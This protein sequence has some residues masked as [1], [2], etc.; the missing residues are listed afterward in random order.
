MA[1]NGSR[2]RD[3][4][5]NARHGNPIQLTLSNGSR[6][7]LPH[8]LLA[9]EVTD[10]G[11]AMLEEY[12]AAVRGAV[13]M[14]IPL[15]MDHLGHLGVKSIIR[16]GKAYEKYNLSWME[17][18][19]PWNYTD[20]LK[21]ISPGKVRRPFSPARDIYLKEPFQ[22]LCEESPPWARFNLTSKL[23]AAFSKRTKSATWPRIMVFPWLCTSRE[24]RWAA[25]P[26][27]IARQLLQNFLALE[28]HSLDVPWW[29]S[30]VEEGVEDSDRQPRLD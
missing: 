2:R 27:C 11:I 24:R 13:G 26:T 22:V 28:N 12:V 10:K 15:S 14:E 9:M 25:W 3:G 20:L 4:R 29:S 23:P 5:Q 16:L 21:Q 1:E 6:I 30:L 19:I 7:Q 18:V 8:P 17:D